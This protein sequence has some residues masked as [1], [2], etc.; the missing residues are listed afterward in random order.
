[1]LRQPTQSQTLLWSMTVLLMFSIQKRY[2]EPS[3]TVHTSIRGLT[4]LS[5]QQLLKKDTSWLIDTKLQA[6]SLQCLLLLFLEDKIGF[7]SKVKSF[8]N[9]TI[10]EVNVTIDRNPHKIFK[11]SILPRNMYPEICKKIIGRTQAPRWWQTGNNYD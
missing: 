5:Y 2:P 9:P 10:K 4:R 11:G 1:M 7:D 6:K 3:K 8:Y